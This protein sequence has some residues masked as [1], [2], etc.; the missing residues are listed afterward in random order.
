MRL[1]VRREGRIQPQVT[2]SA[3]GVAYVSGGAVGGEVVE[4][5]ELGGLELECIDSCN[6]AT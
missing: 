5:E 2:G 6:E 1:L 4:S 3:N